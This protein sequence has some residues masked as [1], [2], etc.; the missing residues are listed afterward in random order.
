MKGA[1]V[2]KKK[3][4]TTSDQ[5]AH[6]EAGVDFVRFVNRLKRTGLC[7]QPTC[8]RVCRPSV[9]RSEVRAAFVNG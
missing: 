9:K 1:A 5:R 8:L 7:V 3:T 4:K 2:F 6:F